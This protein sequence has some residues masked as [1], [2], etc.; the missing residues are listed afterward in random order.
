MEQLNK[1]K[2]YQVSAKHNPWGPGFAPPC[3]G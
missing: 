1:F 3:I 2:Q